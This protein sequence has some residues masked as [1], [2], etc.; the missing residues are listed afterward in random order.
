MRF[1]RQWRLTAAIQISFHDAKLKLLA[2][3]ARLTKIPCERPTLLMLLGYRRWAKLTGRSLRF[4]IF[5]KVSVRVI[6]T[7]V[8]TLL[9][10]HLRELACCPLRSRKTWRGSANLGIYQ[11]QQRNRSFGHKSSLK[12]VHIYS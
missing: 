10:A 2:I 6:I 9:S 12:N 8:E 4:W 3:H 11:L 1:Y 7:I 5:N